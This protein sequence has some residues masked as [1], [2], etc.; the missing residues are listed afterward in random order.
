MPIEGEITHRNLGI[1]T[2]P[3]NPSGKPASQQETSNWSHIGDSIL[4]LQNQITELTEIVN[5]I[6]V[7]EG[8]LPEVWYAHDGRIDSIPKA[9]TNPYFL[10]PTE[11]TVASSEYDWMTYSVLG[12]GITY[13]EIEFTEAGTYLIGYAATV[14]NDSENDA[15]G[16]NRTGTQAVVLFYPQVDTGSGY[17]ALTDGK[18]F[19]MGKDAWS[20]SGDSGDNTDDDGNTGSTASTHFMLVADAGDKV[21]IV[22]INQI[23][24][25]PTSVEVNHHQI[26]VQKCATIA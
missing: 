16:G 22:A 4:N 10:R 5:N 19:C 23:Q 2:T 20:Q 21:R 1:N 8:G 9:N 12:S 25:I 15:G 11:E 3:C 14:A 17:T 7:G 26:W 24:Y 6:E 18:G 13:G